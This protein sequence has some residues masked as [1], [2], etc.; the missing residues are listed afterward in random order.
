MSPVN[1]FKS[2]T[3]MGRNL[4]ISSVLSPLL[5]LLPFLTVAL[6]VVSFGDNTSVQNFF[7]WAIVAILAI[8]LLSYT[9]ILLFSDPKLLRSERHFENMRYIET[10]GDQSHVINV[11]DT[12]PIENNPALPNPQEDIKALVPDTSLRQK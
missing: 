1:A 6:V 9:G 12:L 8:F 11:N 4:R 10:L 5:W 2:A 3:E 7:M